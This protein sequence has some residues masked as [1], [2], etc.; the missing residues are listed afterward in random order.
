MGTVQNP[1]AT[2][3]SNVIERGLGVFSPVARVSFF[4][5]L[6][7]AVVHEMDVGHVQ[8]VLQLNR[9]HFRLLLNRSI[10]F[11]WLLSVRI[12]MKVINPLLERSS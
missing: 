4:V 9:L 10:L 5:A 2:Q 8:E 3:S 6:L 11:F 1:A 12:N 7:G